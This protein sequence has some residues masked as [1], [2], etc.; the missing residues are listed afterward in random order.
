MVPDLRR[1]DVIT[2]LHAL[3]AASQTWI[4]G[5]SPGM[6]HTKMSATNT[7]TMFIK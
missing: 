3:R 5:S 4:P 7:Q 6:T 1:G 2:I